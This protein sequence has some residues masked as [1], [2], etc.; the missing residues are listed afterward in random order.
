MAHRRHSPLPLL[1][2]AEMSSVIEALQGA[3]GGGQDVLFLNDVL[4]VRSERPA[5]SAIDRACAV[6]LFG[7]GPSSP[8]VLQPNELLPCCPPHLQQY[9]EIRKVYHYDYV[10]TCWLGAI[11]TTVC[12]NGLAGAV[13]TRTGQAGCTVPCAPRQSGLRKAACQSGSCALLRPPNRTDQHASPVHFRP[14]RTSRRSRRAPPTC[15]PSPIL[16]C[17]PAARTGC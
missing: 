6:P 13:W 4:R 7:S 17:P 10:S 8:A 12:G 2:L 15:A 11:T 3:F 5:C 9:R 1:P 16:F 14:R